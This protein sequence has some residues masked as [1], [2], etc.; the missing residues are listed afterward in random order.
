MTLIKKA[1]VPR[2]T[3]P[4]TCP[5]KISL[6]SVPEGILHWRMKFLMFFKNFLAWFTHDFSLQVFGLCCMLLVFDDSEIIEGDPGMG[7]KTCKIK[8][9]KLLREIK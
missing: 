5:F 7:T 3:T 1:N 6:K 4:M 9:S 2:S 8:K